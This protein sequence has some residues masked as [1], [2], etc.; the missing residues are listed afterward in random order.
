MRFA[1]GIKRQTRPLEG[2][3]ALDDAQTYTHSMQPG[4]HG[5]KGV[6]QSAA[7]LLGLVLL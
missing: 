3:R 4:N 2:A 7:M 6:Q 1:F 5:E